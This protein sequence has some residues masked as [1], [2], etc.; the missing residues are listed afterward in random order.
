MKIV[1]SNMVCDRCV[2]V[3]GDILQKHNIH[4][5]E[6]SMG[7]INFIEQISSHQLDEL[8]FD[9]VKVGFEIVEA[10]VEKIIESIK[11]TLINHLNNLQNGD[12]I[13]MS[14]FI[15]QHIS[16]DY[17]YLSDIFSKTENK[18][19]EKYFIELRIDK[20]KELLK[21]SNRDIS[22]VAYQLGYSSPQHF[23]S[24]F[25]QY[26]GITPKEFRKLHVIT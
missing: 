5:Y 23:A 12:N 4:D 2:I 11:A 25:K 21:Y 10:K 15:T 9:L 3:I 7:Y 19:I 18:T 8:K 17:S 20:A 26:I 22:T 14:H 1:I 6:I 13:K 24:Q 16:Y